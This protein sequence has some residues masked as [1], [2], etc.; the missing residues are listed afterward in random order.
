[1]NHYEWLEKYL[2]RIFEN[3]KLNYEPYEG[4][5]TAHG[6]KCYQYK[7]EW[8]AAGIHFFHGCALY[9]L[10]FDTTYMTYPRNK[11]CDWVLCMYG[12]HKN[13][14]VPVEP[15]AKYIWFNIQTGEFSNA[16]THEEMIHCG[17]S[18]LIEDSGKSPEYKL[19]KFEC[20]NDPAFTFSN[21]MSVR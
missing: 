12:I 15:E 21:Q 7:D 17:S 1:M 3:F 9:M 5:V 20:L 8:E 11:V 2:P 18:T 13:K 19:I 4:C 16:W 10:S 6:D 14:L